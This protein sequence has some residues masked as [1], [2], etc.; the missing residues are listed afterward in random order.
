MDL[1]DTVSEPS[2]AVFRHSGILSLDYFV[3]T[4]SGP[5]T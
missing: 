2:F 4:S 3:Y 1:K 5:R